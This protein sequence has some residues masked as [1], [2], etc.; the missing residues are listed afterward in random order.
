M[1]QDPAAALSKALKSLGLE[2]EPARV[3]AAVKEHA[4]KNITGRK[5]GEED[6][7]SHKRKGIVGDWKNYFNQEM[8]RLVD[9]EQPLIYQ[10]GYEK[11]KTWLDRLK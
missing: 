5:I 10:L 11:D 8:A 2:P 3:E 6:V 4:F 7:S 9:T 1:H